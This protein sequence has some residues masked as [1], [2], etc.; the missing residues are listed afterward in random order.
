MRITSK[1]ILFVSLSIVI[2]MGVVSWISVRQT[3]EAL[4]KE[5]DNLL[6]STLNFAAEELNKNSLAAKKTSEI[7]AHN[8]AISKALSLDVSAGVNQILNQ[9]LDMYPFYNYIMIVSLDGDI[10][11]IN[12]TDKKGDKIASEELLGHNVMKT[13]L[14]LPPPT[15]SKTVVGS[16]GPDPYL[17]LLGIKARTSQWFVSPVF[18]GPTP[19]GWVVLSYDWQEELSN[20]LTR[21]SNELISYGNPVIDV[22]LVDAKGKVV[23]SAH[24][25]HEEFMQS[26]D[27]EWNEKQLSFGKATMKLII[28]SD[29]S[30]TNEPIIRMRDF[31]IGLIGV[32]TI[33]L[34]GLLYFLLQRTL[35]AKL[36]IIRE[37][38]NEFKSGNLAYRLP[39]LGHDELGSLASTFNE[40]GQSLQ[41]ASQELELK[42]ERRTAEVQESE[43][44]YRLL[45]E[46][47]PDVIWKMD[48]D[49]RFTY[50]NSAIFQ[51]TGYTEDEWIGTRLADHCDEENFKKMAQVASE[52]ISKGTGSSRI[53]F[54]SVMLNKNKQP[55]PVEISGKI[56]FGENALPV[57]LQGI[58][59]DIS[60]RK[61]AEKALRESESQ[62][63]AILDGIT[64]NIA[65]VNQD[66]EILWANKTAADSVGKLPS[67]MIGHKCHSLWADDAKPCDG[68]PTLKAFKTKKS[69][70]ITMVTPDGR[71][72][73]EK[74]EPV[75]DAEGSLLGVVEIATDITEKVCTEQ[76]KQ[77]LQT[78]LFQSQKLEALGTLVGGIAHDFNNM[79]QIILGYSELL[80]IGKKRDDPVYKGLQT[81]I[82]TGQGGAE[83]IKKLLALGQQGQMVSVPLDLN[84]Q[85]SRLTTL[86]SRTLP[87]VVQLDIDLTH[88]PMTIHAD[89]NQIDQ[90]VMH[91]AINASEAMPNGG[92]LKIATTAV[93]L[94]DEYCR[95]HHRAK[96]D[97]YVMLSVKDDGCGMDKDTL[98]RIFD[99]FFSTKQRG[100]TR[101][102]GLGLSVVQGIVQQHG[103]HVICESEPGRGTEFKIYFP[104]IE[105]TL[106]TP[107]TVAPIVKRE[108]TE[109]ILVVEDNI[110]V[111]ELEQTTLE[112]AGYTVIMA[113]NGQEALDIY[114]T[115]K[116]QIWLVILDLMMPEMSGKDCLMELVK[117]DPAVKVLIA[118]GY[119]PE[120]ELHKEINPLIKGFVHKPFELTQFLDEVGSVLRNNQR[121]QMGIMTSQN[122]SDELERNEITQ[123]PIL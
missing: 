46:N 45:S 69:E 15:K 62:K 99:P 112:D 9:M 122:R 59:R 50:V 21:V 74:G 101:G 10:F 56:I 66:M 81:I 35:L 117:I 28:A 2:V 113:T 31:F 41:N 65:F 67:Q 58:T 106:I 43:E 12:T 54:E 115:K 68:C 18:K 109:T 3:E 53:I 78:Q 26:P 5:I 85:I 17:S 34:L 16:P 63:Q 103:G 95:L 6:T 37:G 110:P 79:L 44:K 73:D 13:P 33:V 51:V 123:I 49:L 14:F 90:V 80:L 104:A 86:I 39:S 22:A 91:L 76:E 4:H 82:Q 36:S 32:A 70:H 92:R 27:Q 107:K 100:S 77:A 105:E 83:L 120:D 7:I 87:R 29:R 60:E 57:A 121:V 19:I 48:L 20:L 38:T 88:G 97:N 114:Q 108:G 98:A 93:S 116:D 30:K 25:L 55:F 40:M 61:R 24:S 42:V 8:P 119:A 47:T 52:E 23:V 84:H 72:W 11:A 102:T 64:I 111:A 71:V 1:I 94:D 75:F 96:P 118:S 89:P